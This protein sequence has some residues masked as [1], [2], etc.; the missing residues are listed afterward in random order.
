MLK[1]NVEEGKNFLIAKSYFPIHKVHAPLH[2]KML[3]LITE[4]RKIFQHITKF[5]LDK[6]T[7]WKAKRTTIIITLFP[8]HLLF[9]LT[10]KSYHKLKVFRKVQ[11]NKVV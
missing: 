3:I 7:P 10:F 8:F 11:N 2:K 1:D 5:K 6:L 9:L 4:M